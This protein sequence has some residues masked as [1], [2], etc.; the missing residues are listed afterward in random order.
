[1][2]E[3]TPVTADPA[4][5]VFDAD[6][7]AVSIVDG[8]APS[9]VQFTAADGTVH[10]TGYGS[11]AH[12]NHINAWLRAEKQFH[13]EQEA[14][15]AEQAAQLKKDAADAAGSGTP[16]DLGVNEPASPP[17]EVE[18]AK[19]EVAD[20][21]AQA[22]AQRAAAK[23]TRVPTPGQSTTTADTAAVKPAQ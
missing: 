4:V 21:R 11:P 20:K 5:A 8:P 16:I 10:S 2:S 22:D 9:V 19:S 17:A 3:T 12:L 15:A 1:M 23:G 6:G 18:A 7:E 14:E 13:A